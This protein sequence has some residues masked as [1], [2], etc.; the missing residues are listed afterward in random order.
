MSR[1]NLVRPVFR[2]PL[3]RNTATLLPEGFDD[4]F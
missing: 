3:G 4:T 2:V 1:I